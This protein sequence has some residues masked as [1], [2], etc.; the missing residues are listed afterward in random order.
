MVWACTASAI[1]GGV[2]SYLIVVSLP[3]L[4]GEL[5]PATATARTPKDLQDNPFA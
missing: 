1:A 3:D 2:A 5:A 4:S